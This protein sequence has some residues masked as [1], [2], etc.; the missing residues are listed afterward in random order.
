M[1][2]PQFYPFYITLS[3][4]DD[5]GLPYRPKHVVVDVIN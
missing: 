1:P 5:D 4:P 3:I 2:V